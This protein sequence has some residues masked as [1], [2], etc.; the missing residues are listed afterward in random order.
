MRQ[1]K[2]LEFL[3]DYDLEINYHLG[4]MN[5][6]ADALSRKSQTI[7]AS[8]ITTQKELLRDL[9]RMGIEFRKYQPN[10][11][12]SAIEIQLSIIDKIKVAQK[13]DKYLQ[14]MKERSKETDQSD[15]SIMDD[16]SLW[17]N[18]RLCVPDNLELKKKIMKKSHSTPYTAHPSSTK[19]YQDLKS[20]Y[21][22]TN[23][24]REVAGYI[25]QCLTCQQVKMEHQWPAGPLQSL[26]IP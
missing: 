11:M 22:W 2:W 10:A 7:M 20:T 3:V 17:C 9:E 4:K 5:M 6:V 21:W 24:K 14:A 25:A 18:N 12:L 15:F 1:R 8:A 13:E 19:M 16:G 26:E 23:M